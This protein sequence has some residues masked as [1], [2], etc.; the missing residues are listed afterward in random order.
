[1]DIK[2]NNAAKYA[3][4]A[5]LRKRL[6]EEREFLGLERR[7]VSEMIGCTYRHY[8]EF[9]GDSISIPIF[10]LQ[11]LADLYGLTLE[12]I[13]TEANAAREAIVCGNKSLT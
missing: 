9:E 11:E 12:D 4:Y 5:A 7:D 2:H 13:L 6:K 3:F 10:Y 8:L 1:M